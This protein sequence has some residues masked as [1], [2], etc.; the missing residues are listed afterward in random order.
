VS[1]ATAVSFGIPILF[2]LVNTLIPRPQLPQGCH[3]EGR[4]KRKE[5]E[6]ARTYV[7]EK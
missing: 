3:E 4:G 5:R 2:D 7:L 1:L 6:K